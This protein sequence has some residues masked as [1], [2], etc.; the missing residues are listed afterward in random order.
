MR[1]LKTKPVKE[2]VIIGLT[3]LAVV[4][5]SYQSSDYFNRSIMD[6]LLGETG[7]SKGPPPKNWANAQQHIEDRHF[8]PDGTAPDWFND[9]TTYSDVQSLGQDAYNYGKAEQQPDGRWRYVYDTGSDIGD[10]MKLDSSGRPVQPPVVEES[11]VTVVVLVTD[12]DGNVITCF[13]GYDYQK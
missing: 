12:K 8:Y 5:L 9:G 13:P 3:V 6:M 2:L 7:S 11:N 10:R 4:L 1:E